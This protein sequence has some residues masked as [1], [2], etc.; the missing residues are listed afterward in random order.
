LLGANKENDENYEFIDNVL[1]NKT[2]DKK[3]ITKRNK[4]NQYAQNKPIEEEH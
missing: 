4:L 3:H 2:I 1:S